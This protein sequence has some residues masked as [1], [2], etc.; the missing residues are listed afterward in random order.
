MNH[1]K[2]GAVTLIALVQYCGACRC[3]NKGPIGPIIALMQTFISIIALT[4]APAGL[5]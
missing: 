2:V 5:I 4:T 1:S 3:S